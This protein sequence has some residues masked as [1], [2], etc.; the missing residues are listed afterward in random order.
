MRADTPSG[1][2]RGRGV[3][4]SASQNWSAGARGHTRA[5]ADTRTDVHTRP[6]AEV[7]GAGP[8]YY[9]WRRFDIPSQVPPLTPGTNKKMAEAL[10]ATFASWEKE[11]LRL[12]VPKEVVIV[13]GTVT[14]IFVEA[15]TPR[16]GVSFKVHTTQCTHKSAYA[17]GRT[18]GR[19]LAPRAHL[20][21]DTVRAK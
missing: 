7:T 4:I 14:M 20:L 11:Q 12:G 1:G 2:D 8:A 18:A 5:R 6:P 19:A 17:N 16:K 10:K 9:E 13:T 15:E 21:Y 3:Q